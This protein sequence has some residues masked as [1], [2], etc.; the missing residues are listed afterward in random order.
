MPWFIRDTKSDVRSFSTVA[1][2]AV[3][4]SHGEREEQFRLKAVGRASPHGQLQPLVN[5]R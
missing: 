3:R 2:G 5:G 1:G 4:H